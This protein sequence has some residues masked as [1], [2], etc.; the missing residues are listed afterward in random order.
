[1]QHDEVPAPVATKATSQ[2]QEQAAH[3]WCF[4]CMHERDDL[5]HGLS[6]EIFSPYVRAFH[7]P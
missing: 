3:G 1:M 6:L 7:I 5:Q 4:V 2:H